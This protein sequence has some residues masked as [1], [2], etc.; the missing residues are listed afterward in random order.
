M[1]TR[2]VF[3]QTVTYATC[4][5]LYKL[6]Q[7]IEIVATVVWLILLVHGQTGMSVQW[8]VA[9][10]QSSGLEAVLHIVKIELLNTKIVIW[11]AVQ[12]MK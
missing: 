11:I 5:K 6:F 7:E 3:A 1:Q 9:M 4:T 10:E 12:V 8:H 2:H